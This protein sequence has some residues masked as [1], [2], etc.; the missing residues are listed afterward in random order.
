MA[1]LPV[2]T[3]PG[4][5][6]FQLDH[7]WCWWL[8]KPFFRI[9]TARAFKDV[10]NYMIWFYCNVI[11]L[12][13]S[14][15]SWLCKACFQFSSPPASCHRTFPTQPTLG[16]VFGTSPSP[17]WSHSK[18]SQNSKISKVSPALQLSGHTVGSGQERS[19]Q[20]IARNVHLSSPVHGASILFLPAFEA[21][22]VDGVP[23]LRRIVWKFQFKSIRVES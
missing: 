15:I 2:A 10:T 11:Y 8:Q 23:I 18:L 5:S 9:N 14:L 7:W 3:L 4:V 6:V 16:N 1:K 17:V 12:Y 20:R 13:T 22:H 19:G 21:M